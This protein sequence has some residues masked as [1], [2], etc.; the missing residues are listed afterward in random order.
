MIGITRLYTGRNTP[1]DGLRY[2]VQRTEG[3]RARDIVTLHP[4][5]RAA[6]RKPVVV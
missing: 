1:S 2:G 5:R 6:D 4:E 3:V